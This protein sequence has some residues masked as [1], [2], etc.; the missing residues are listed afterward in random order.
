M[1]S[2]RGSSESLGHMK[3]QGVARSPAIRE[4]AAAT[5][6][7]MKRLRCHGIRTKSL[8]RNTLQLHGLSVMGIRPGR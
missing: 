4:D 6:D 2:P 5:T 1:A 3:V 8:G 7:H